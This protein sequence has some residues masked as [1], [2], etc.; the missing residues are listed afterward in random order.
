MQPTNA[1][2]TCATPIANSKKSIDAEKTEHK[3]PSSQLSPIVPATP[4]EALEEFRSV[5]QHLA[6][7][8]LSAPTWT[9]AHGKDT[10]LLTTPDVQAKSASAVPLTLT[11]QKNEHQQ[12]AQIP[13]DAAEA[14][15]QIQTTLDDTQYLLATCQ[16]EVYTT[17]GY[18]Y[19]TSVQASAGASCG[20]SYSSSPYDFH[21]QSQD[22]MKTYDTNV[23]IEV[24]CGAAALSV[25][26][27]S[28]VSGYAVAGC[29]SGE[30]QQL[31]LQYEA[32]IEFPQRFTTKQ[33]TRVRWPAAQFC[34]VVHVEFKRGRVRRFFS[35]VLIK[36][37]SYALVPGDR[38][39]DCGLVIQCALWNPYKH[40]YD[41]DTVQSLDAEIW[42]PGNHGSIMEVI[43]LATDD[44]VRRLHS[45]H[46]SMER[47]ALN[48]CR[49]VAGRLRL[50]MEV[51]D[52]EY[53]YDG[54]KISFFFDSA[55]TID[56]RELNKELYRIF[57]AR[58]WMQNTNTAVRNAAPSK[59][60]GSPRWRKLHGGPPSSN[61]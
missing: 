5:R 25:Q 42:P 28:V 38:G 4:A 14:L 45:E 50:P 53:Q 29:R 43:R 27:T 56:F 41:A 34:Y 18:Q 48:T 51:L 8:L 22:F 21:R 35:R 61:T 19:Q 17:L 11:P 40:S 39:Y 9:R 44:E 52:C 47:V 32:P 54:T 33:P 36:P 49:D 24:A 10:K 58:I 15:C 23:P 3:T 20:I 6:R 60:T 31:Q 26:N 2:G 12:V 16:N 13:S 37:A 57:N 1:I 59:I 55:A 7:L 46:A 30:Q